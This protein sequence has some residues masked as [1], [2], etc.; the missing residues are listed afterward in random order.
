MVVPPPLFDNVNNLETIDAEAGQMPLD[1]NPGP[2]TDKEPT[3]MPNL[4]NLD[5]ADAEENLGPG[6]DNVATPTL[7]LTNFD[8]VDTEAGRMPLDENLGPRTDKEPTLTPAPRAIE[9][10]VDKRVDS[11]ST[12]TDVTNDPSTAARTAN[13]PPANSPP[14]L[15]RKDTNT[16]FTVTFTPRALGSPP[17]AAVCPKPRPAYTTALLERA[18]AEAEA[19][20]KAAELKLAADVEAAKTLASSVVGTF[21][22]VSP[23]PCLPFPPPD[24][25]PSEVKTSHILPPEM[26]L[27]DNPPSGSHCRRTLTQFGLNHAKEVEERNAKA[28]KLK[29]KKAGKGPLNKP[30]VVKAIGKGKKRSKYCTIS[31][32]SS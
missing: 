22:A 5:M 16:P 25:H 23:P 6:T 24:A 3:P 27:T 31:T 30:S 2:R 17:K 7:N 4:T 10:A 19:A 13:V 18:K 26:A 29:L 8:M 12:L 32:V 15:S 9:K 1:E 20:A 21:T 14:R 28:E 11:L